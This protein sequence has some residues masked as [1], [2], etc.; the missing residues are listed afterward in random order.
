MLSA[1]CVHVTSIYVILARFMY[2]H[3]S[4]GQAR[5]QFVWIACS[6]IISYLMCK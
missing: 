2:V 4:F 6:L 5:T 1:E 3:I